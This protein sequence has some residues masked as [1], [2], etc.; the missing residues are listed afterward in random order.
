M[1][2]GQADQVPHRPGHL[3][4]P[5]LQEALA[6]PV[7]AHDRG[8]VP[9]DGGLLGYDDDAHLPIRRAR[10]AGQQMLIAFDR[11]RNQDLPRQ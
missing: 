3:V 11:P 7:R 6:P 8:D 9:R 1:G 2:L 5:A 10:C 4:A